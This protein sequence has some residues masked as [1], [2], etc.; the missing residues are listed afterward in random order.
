[1]PLNE[2]VNILKPRK[3]KEYKEKI[4]CYDYKNP[5]HFRA[6]CLH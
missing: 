5:R 2:L 4:V 3:K 1:M 6:E